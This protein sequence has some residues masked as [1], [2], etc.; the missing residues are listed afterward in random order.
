MDDGLEYRC[1]RIGYANGWII[2]S[3]KGAVLVD[4]GYDRQESRFVYALRRMGYRP[5]DLRLIVITHA[6][7]DHFGALAAIKRY[8]GATVIVHEAEAEYLRTGDPIMPKALSVW[9]KMWLALG[10]K[11]PDL[12]KVQPVEPDIVVSGEVDLSEWGID[13]RLIETPGHSP[14]SM[15]VLFRGGTA[16][17]GD[18]AVSSFRARFGVRAAGFGDDPEELTASWRKLVAAG[19]HRICPGHGKPYPI[20]CLVRLIEKADG[21]AG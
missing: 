6:H 14:G 1:A 13:A 11:F 16:F 20:K 5:R 18:V 4:A 3:R 8:T 7:L 12:L 21:R 17:A 2:R 10:R 15:S 9:G 19:V